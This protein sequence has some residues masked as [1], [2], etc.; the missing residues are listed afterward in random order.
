MQYDTLDYMLKQNPVFEKLCKNK[1]K[2][3][4]NNHIN[5]LIL[6]IKSLP[7]EMFI[8]EVR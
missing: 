4:D 3:S 6:V 7:R 8:R 5:F 1:I 2:I